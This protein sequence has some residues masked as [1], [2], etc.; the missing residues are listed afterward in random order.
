MWAKVI[1][2]QTFFEC[3]FFPFDHDHPRKTT[4]QQKNGFHSRKM[5]FPAENAP[6]CGETGFRGAL[7]RKLQDIAEGFQGS[8]IKNANM[9]SQDMKMRMAWEVHSSRVSWALMKTLHGAS[10]YAGLNK[11]QSLSRN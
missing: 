10:D 9:A 7:C 6:S 3:H 5:N 4:I 11:L 8:R 2:I 1:K